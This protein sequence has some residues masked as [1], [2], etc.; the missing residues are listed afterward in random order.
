MTDDIKSAVDIPSLVKQLQD[1]VAVCEKEGWDH[2]AAFLK[3]AADTIGDLYERQQ[4]LVTL[5]FERA[6]QLSALASRVEKIEAETVERCAK[7]AE[8]KGEEVADRNAD[9]YWQ[10]QRIA[11]SIRALSQPKE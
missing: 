3:S 4:E 2:T 6:E 5:G 1:E 7:V 9:R 10:S 11:R 8:V